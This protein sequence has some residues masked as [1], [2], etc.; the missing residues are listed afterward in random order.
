MHMH[1]D[2]AYA[3][4]QTS[5]NNTHLIGLN[6]HSMTNPNSNMI[7]KDQENYSSG[8]MPVSKHLSSP[9]VTSMCGSNGSHLTTL[10]QSSH[11]QLLL[12][13]NI[14]DVYTHSQGSP[15]IN[16]TCV[17]EIHTSHIKSYPQS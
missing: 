7:R 5:G 9:N 17:P 2:S 4:I 13:F 11:G 12:T 1:S 3:D 15:S 14:D 6:L 8:V 16:S 10:D